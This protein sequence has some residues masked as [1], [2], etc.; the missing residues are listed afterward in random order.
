MFSEKHAIDSYDL[1]FRVGMWWRIV[2]GSLRLLL[3]FALFRIIGTPIADIFYKIMSHELI[4]DPN[5]FFMRISNPFF[6]NLT[7]SVTYFLAAYFIFWGII[8]IFL[9]INLL[10]HKKWAFPI[11]IYFIGFFVLYELYRFFHT[12]SLTLVGIICID[13][14]VMWLIRKEYYTQKLV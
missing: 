5:D 11:S 3:G 10:Q 8:D 2:Y 1:L 12:Y 14:V 4:E 6:Q 7:L 13:L 9:S